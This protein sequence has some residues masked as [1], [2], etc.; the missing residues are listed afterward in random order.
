M[1]FSWTGY[2]SQ[3][4]S[5]FISITSNAGNCDPVLRPVSGTYLAST[6]G[7]WEGAVGFKYNQ[8][9]F[10]FQF[11][12]MYQ[13][14]EEYQNGINY[15]KNVIVEYLGNYSTSY[16]LA[17]MILVLT[18]YQLIFPISGS[19]QYVLF[20]GSPNV[21]FNAVD[22]YGGMA[23]SSATCYPPAAH[24]FDSNSAVMSISVGY[25]DFVT[26]CPAFDPF[27]FGFLDN[28]IIVLLQIDMRSFV[29]AMG[30]NMGI[31]GAAL[32]LE[33]VEFSQFVIDLYQ[34]SIEVDGMVFEAVQYYSIRYPGMEPFVCVISTNSIIFSAST[35][36]CFMELS[37]FYGIPIMNP[38]GISG[39]EPSPCN[40][41]EP[42]LGTLSYCN[43]FSLLYGLDLVLEHVDRFAISNE[44]RWTTPDD[45]FVLLWSASLCQVTTM[46]MRLC[47]QGVDQGRERGIDEIGIVSG[48]EAIDFLPVAITE[49]FHREMT[50]SSVQRTLHLARLLRQV[51]LND[52][53]IRLLDEPRHG[54][55]E[56]PTLVHIQL[57]AD[58][59]GTNLKRVG[60]NCG[61]QR[62]ASHGIGAINK[63]KIHRSFEVEGEGDLVEADGLNGVLVGCRWGLDVLGMENHAI[64]DLSLGDSFISHDCD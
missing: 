2:N 13:T 28:D 29:M 45:A 3:R 10:E 15:A 36:L 55:G 51:A 64:P 42:E 63:P 58:D 24:T 21:I 33:V 54:H 18:T 1:E 44:L 8:A 57:S 40:C 27:L 4:K 5:K 6:N 30:T 25:S 12:N 26:Y 17:M 50:T 61:N 53:S 31:P 11:F 38:V 14:Q 9:L 16:N 39:D 37:G 35:P 7:E 20:T 56:G 41:S 46:I 23:S 34:T 62:L 22:Y 52:G 48:T 49:N 43:A 60:D 59:H 47:V 19:N 32:S